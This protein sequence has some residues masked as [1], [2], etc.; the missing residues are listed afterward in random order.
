[1]GPLSEFQQDFTGLLTD[2]PHLFDLAA[3]LDRDSFAKAHLLR[4]LFKLL[5]GSSSIPRVVA[6]IGFDTHLGHRH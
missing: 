4:L 6:S 2:L 5:S 1:L 3:A